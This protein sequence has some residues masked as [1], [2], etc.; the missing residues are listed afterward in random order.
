MLDGLS[1]LEL[2]AIVSQLRTDKNLAVAPVPAASERLGA[3]TEQ[4]LRLTASGRLSVPES[5]AARDEAALQAWHIALGERVVGPLQVSALRAH[6]E[7]GEL[8]PDSLCWRKGFEGWQRVCQVPGLAEC[9]AP[10][11]ATAPSSP[12]ELVPDPNADALDFPLKGA[13]AL[14]ILAEEIPPPLPSRQPEVPP[15]VLEEEPVT[16][17]M[18]EPEPPTV[19]EAL[20]AQA[21]A[22][23]HPILNAQP[24]TQVEVRVRGG[25]WLALS[26]GIVGGMLV[27][28]AMWL[29]GLSATWGQS[30]RGTSLQDST[31]ATA[32]TPAATANTPT[33]SVPAALKP[34]A[35]GLVPSTGTN[36]AGTPALSASTAGVPAVASGSLHAPTLGTFSGLGSATASLK[37]T[38][39]PAPLSKPTV[40]KSDSTETL[41]QAASPT[42]QV[43]FDEPP[44]PKRAKAEVSALASRT[45]D[46]RGAT[47]QD[48]VE[49]DDSD[50]LGLDKE[51]ERELSDPAK[52]AV[53][54]KRTVYI[55]PDPKPLE[56]PASLA[57]SDIFSVVVSNKGDIT[58]C[59]SAQKLQSDEST[60]RVV[61]RWTI[62]PS[63]KVTD[64]DTET[65]AYQG[66]PLALC[67]EGR[68]RAWTFPKHQ[69][70]GSPVRF[71]FVF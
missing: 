39:V 46:A 26:G 34:E 22:G 14:R 3:V 13:E 66:T 24:P 4:R 30:S 44:M 37:P 27:A 51:F 31:S 6:W 1:E 17:P 50:D 70:Q 11:T 57:Q 71:P 49:E 12:E 47:Q 10:R 29:L 64:V 63:G 21:A 40:Q 38:P 43:T 56:A 67:L 28:L 69:E 23:V 48:A 5:E 9:L 19:P 58:E 45:G 65:R 59:V 18:L 33:P 62:L 53:P 8:G 7:R 36:P 60:R 42:R 68:I 2:D 15:P 54:A 35:M 52:R 61:M 25:G 20:Q 16:A 41:K 32:S 55:P